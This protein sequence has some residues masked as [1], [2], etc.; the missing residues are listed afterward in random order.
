MENPLLI[1]ICIKI[2]TKLNYLTSHLT[3]I[4]SQNRY[5]NPSVSGTKCCQCLGEK[6]VYEYTQ[7]NIN[8][9]APLFC[10]R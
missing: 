3:L 10:D 5:K 2:F 7:V 8:Q 6:E 1:I 4:Q 9:E